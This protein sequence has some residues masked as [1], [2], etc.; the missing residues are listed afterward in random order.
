MKTV[1]NNI[2]D[3][4]GR[5][6]CYKHDV[7]TSLKNFMLDKC[8]KCPYF[9]GDLQNTGVSCKFDDA[10]NEQEIYF[11]DAGDSELHSKMQFGR[12]G[13]ADKEDIIKTLKSYNDYD[14]AEKTKETEEENSDNPPDEDDKKEDSK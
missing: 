10:C 6:Y 11:N 5:I 2:V 1:H 8:L 7:L 4:S 12:L 9:N 13:L 14:D 3:S